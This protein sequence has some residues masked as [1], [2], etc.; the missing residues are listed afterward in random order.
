[1]TGADQPGREQDA[2][3]DGTAWA[4]PAIVVEGVSKSFEPNQVLDGIDL[5]V[6]AHEVICLIGASG[7]GKSTL[8]RCINLLEPISG[9]RIWLLGQDVTA[10][11]IDANAVRRQ[12]GIV[13]QSYN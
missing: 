1:M 8:L 5:S 12:V 10:P 6:A 11:G 2:W 9:G 4:G 3:A 7:S 13:F